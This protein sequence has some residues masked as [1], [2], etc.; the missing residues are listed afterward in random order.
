MY[1]LGNTISITYQ[2]V[3]ARSGKTILME[4]YDET[5]AL[6]LAQ[7]NTIG[8]TEIN[9]TGRYYDT[10][11]PDTKGEWTVICWEKVGALLKRGHV[12][13]AFRIGDYDLDVVGATLAGVD[14]KIDSVDTKIS[15]VE[16][17]VDVVDG[18]VDAI[19]LKT[20]NLP[21]DP[22][23][24]SKQD[25]IITN[26]ASIVAAIGVIDGIVDAIKLKTD[27]LPSDPA[28]ESLVESAIDTA[29]SNIRGTDS[30]DLKTLS[31]QIDSL[32]SP[33]MVG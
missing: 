1:A 16:T 4:V 15:T 8:L 10:F 5:H 28:S 25:T 6:S 13:A 19:K 18:V 32:E 7:S 33:A 23:K 9:A 17:K 2:A 21:V 26:Q 12:V 30:D 22:A 29:E 3:G 24:E 14:T 31:D 20:D 27:N 11:V